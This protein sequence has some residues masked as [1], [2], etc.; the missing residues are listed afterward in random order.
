[1]GLQDTQKLTDGELF[2]II[3]NGV[4]LTGMPAWGPADDSGDEDSW[5]LVH[6]IRHIPALTPEEIKE[7]EALNPKSPADIEEEKADREFLG[8]ADTEPPKKSHQHGR[9]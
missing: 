2:S 5:K 9:N 3:H 4:R 6:F 1:M 7:M 8:G